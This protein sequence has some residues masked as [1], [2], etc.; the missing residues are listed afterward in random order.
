MTVAWLHLVACLYL[1]ILFFFLMIRRPPRS[2]LFPY[3][4]LFRSRG[5]AGES[6]GAEA[7]AGRFSRAAPRGFCRPERARPRDSQG[8]LP[9]ARRTEGRHPARRASDDDGR[10]RVVAPPGPRAVRTTPARD[11]DEA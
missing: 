2:T 4:T 3:T 6:R 10:P 11:R 7:P 5:D 9:P 1:P 8:G